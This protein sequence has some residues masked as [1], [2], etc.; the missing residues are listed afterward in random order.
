MVI[1]SDAVQ[2]RNSALAASGL[3]GTLSIVIPVLNE[4]HHLLELLP[5]LA[6]QSMRPLEVL[7]ADAD[8]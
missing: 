5:Q 3:P 4:A 8:S 6:R 1:S 2:R 7:V